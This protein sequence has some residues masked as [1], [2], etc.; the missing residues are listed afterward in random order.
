MGRSHAFHFHH[1]EHK[2]SR[3]VIPRL[4]RC[5]LRRFLTRFLGRIKG[6]SRENVS[7]QTLRLEQELAFYREYLVQRRR[8]FKYSLRGL[9]P[10]DSEVKA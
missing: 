3:L 6:E 9:V 1:W 7:E 4:V 10:Q 5:H 8:P 2:R